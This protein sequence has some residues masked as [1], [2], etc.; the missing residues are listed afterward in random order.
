[1]SIEYTECG[2]A[3]GHIPHLCL[4]DSL[5]SCLNTTLD[6]ASGLIAEEEQFISASTREHKEIE[7]RSSMVTRHAARVLRGD[8]DK[9]RS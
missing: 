6:I 8:E 2:H 3:Q 7:I 5:S 4:I 1:M 9:G